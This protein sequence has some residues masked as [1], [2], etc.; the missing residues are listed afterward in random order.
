MKVLFHAAAIALVLIS[1]AFAQKTNKEN[2]VR[3]RGQTPLADETQTLDRGRLGR[4]A[5]IP[6]GALT[7]HGMLVDASCPDRSSGNL[8]QGPEKRNLVPAQPAPTNNGGVSSH[9]VTVDSKTIQTERADVMPHQV[10]DMRSR[11][12]DPTC[13]ITASTRGLAMLLDNGRLLNLDE[14]G[15][16]LALQQI[17]GSASG[18][19]MLNGS[20][21]G[22]KPHAV[23][24]GTIHGDRLTVNKIVRME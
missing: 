2:E 9:G 8:A 19:A 5:A 3:D 11:A 7:L 16:T 15:N 13:A 10:P 20:A 1:G 17:D 4:Q 21:P 6:A 24:V 18:R 12:M 14:G 23:I 22:L